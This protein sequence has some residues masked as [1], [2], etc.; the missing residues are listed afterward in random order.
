MLNMMTR[1]RHGYT[2]RCAEPYPY[3]YPLGYTYLQVWVSLRLRV[4]QVS[5]LQHYPSRVNWVDPQV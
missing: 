3:P 2:R 1:V 5:Y 4:W